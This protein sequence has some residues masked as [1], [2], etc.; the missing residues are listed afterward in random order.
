[1]NFINLRF[2]SKVKEEA[3][4]IRRKV[5]CRIFFFIEIGNDGGT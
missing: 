4:K 3:V 1:M 5:S 2:L